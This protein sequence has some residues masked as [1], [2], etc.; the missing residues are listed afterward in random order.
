MPNLFVRSIRKKDSEHFGTRLLNES[1]LHLAFT[2][3]QSDILDSI[4]KFIASSIMYIFNH[5]R[6]RKSSQVL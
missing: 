3:S 1:T 6:T 4:G 2:L 5:C